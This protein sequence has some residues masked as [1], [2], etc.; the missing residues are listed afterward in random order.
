MQSLIQERASHLL[1][2]IKDYPHTQTEYHRMFDLIIEADQ[3]FRQV[4]TQY[5]SAYKQLTEIEQRINSLQGD[6]KNTDQQ[7]EGNAIDE[8][9]KKSPI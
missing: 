4:E 5:S 7:F 6:W 3:R 2:P 1:K 8:Y 9:P